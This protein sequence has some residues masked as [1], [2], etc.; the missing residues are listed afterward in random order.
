MFYGVTH[1]QMYTNQ[2]CVTNARRRYHLVINLFIQE[3]REHRNTFPCRKLLSN[4][5][6]YGKYAESTVDVQHVR[7]H[8]GVIIQWGSL[9]FPSKHLHKTSRW[10]RILSVFS[11]FATAEL[12]CDV[13]L[14]CRPLW[15]LSFRLPAFLSFFPPFFYL[16]SYWLSVFHP[17]K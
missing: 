3:K 7:E 5:C 1:E 16:L 17:L 4:N 14:W 10:K 9:F 11:E 12:F 2:R 6:Y 15:F 8:T 13:W